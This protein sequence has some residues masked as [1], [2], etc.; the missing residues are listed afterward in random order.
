MMTFLLLLM[1][2]VTPPIP[3]IIPTTLG[4]LFPVGWPLRA[5]NDG[6]ICPYVQHA[7]AVD[8]LPFTEQVTLS[9]R[10]T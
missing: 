8:L 5:S 3:E 1:E 9:D 4:L 6:D 2:T 7:R 10:F